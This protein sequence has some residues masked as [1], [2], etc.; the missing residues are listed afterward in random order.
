MGKEDFQNNIKSVTFT[1]TIQ[2]H[3]HI[4]G[5]KTNTMSLYSEKEVIDTNRITSW[6]EYKSFGWNMGVARMA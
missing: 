6:M 4:N 5:R 1:S 2:F 3:K